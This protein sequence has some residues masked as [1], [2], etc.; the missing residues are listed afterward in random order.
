M[1]ITE[2]NM[3]LQE[4][5]RRGQFGARQ[6]DHFASMAA[7]SDRVIEELEKRNHL[8]AEQARHLADHE[9]LS[10]RRIEELE[11]RPQ[12]A[13]QQAAHLTQHAQD[14]LNNT[15]QEA[16]DKLEA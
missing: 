6:A 1:H 12:F 15:N 4:A 16:D 2:I 9:R 10:D 14:Q 13:K 8:A 3:K 7:A 5:D 11:H